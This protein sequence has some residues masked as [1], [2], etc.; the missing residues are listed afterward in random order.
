MVIKRESLSF[1]VALV[2]SSQGSISLTWET[3]C[4]LATITV[5]PTLIVVDTRHVN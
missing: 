3:F 2:S 4:I 1:S 5:L